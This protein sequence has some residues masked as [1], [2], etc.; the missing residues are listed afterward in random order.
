MELKKITQKQSFLTSASEK[1]IFAKIHNVR[2]NNDVINFQFNELIPLEDFEKK[3]SPSYFLELTSKID[4]ISKGLISY[5]SDE[6]LKLYCKETENHI[7]IISTGE[8]QPSLY[9]IFIEGIF[10]KINF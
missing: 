3:V 4:S 6:G 1:E 9:K 10:E 5:K 2:F 8:Y 7:L